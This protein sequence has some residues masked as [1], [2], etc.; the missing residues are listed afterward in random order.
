MGVRVGCINWNP[1]SSPALREELGV[2]NAEYGECAKIIVTVTFNERLW[3]LAI[4]QRAFHKLTSLTLPRN[5]MR[6][7]HHYSHFTDEK[8]EAQS[9]LNLLLKLSEVTEQSQ[10]DVGRAKRL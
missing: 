5:Q 1:P 6:L 3:C 4:V 7:G 9:R 8:T 2:F 10:L